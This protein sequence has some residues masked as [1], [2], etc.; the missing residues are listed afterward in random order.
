[1]KT[2]KKSKRGFTLIEIMIAITI[3]AAIVATLFTNV[4]AERRKSQI[5]QARI[6]L[7]QLKG[8][9]DRF[10]LDCNFYPNTEEGLRALIDGVPRCSAFL[11]SYIDKKRVPQDP[12]G[13][14]L[15]YEYD[16]N[17]RGY[18]LCTLGAD[19]SLGGTKYDTDICS[20]EL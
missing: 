16:E 9:L 5:S 8:A 19:G 11:E 12:W 10:N 17:T 1:M 15:L 18:E 7:S 3:L 13:N 14:P 20:D 6:L 2:I 4:N